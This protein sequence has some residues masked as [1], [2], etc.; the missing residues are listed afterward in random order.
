MR[1]ARDDALE[2]LRQEAQKTA[3]LGQEAMKVS[4]DQTQLQ[5]ELREMQAARDDALE[6]LTQE[7]QTPGSHAGDN[8]NIL[9]LQEE[10]ESMKTARDDA[11]EKLRQE[12]QRLESA[13][14]GDHADLSRL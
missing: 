7:M 9:R 8:A 11:L 4:W 6:K 1:T 3:F 10:L 5:G 2:K 14:A 12:A 13:A